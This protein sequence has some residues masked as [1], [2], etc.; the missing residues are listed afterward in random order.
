MTMFDWHDPTQ[1]VSQYI[2]V[3]AAITLPVT[4]ILL[5]IWLLFMK[6]NN[7]RHKAEELA[8]AETYANV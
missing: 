6:K 7:Q 2:W 8:V 4:L 5:A 1:V 3:Y